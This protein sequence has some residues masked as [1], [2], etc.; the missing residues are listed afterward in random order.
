MTSLGKI[1]VILKENIQALS[2]IMVVLMATEELLIN[3]ATFGKVNGRTVK[4]MD[5][6]EIIGKM[7]SIQLVYTMKIHSFR[8]KHSKIISLSR[9]THKKSV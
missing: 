8:V 5:S 7:D 4:L 6:T 1:R 3:T 2:T 9:N